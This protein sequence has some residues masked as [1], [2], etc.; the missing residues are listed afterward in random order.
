MGHY[1]THLYGDCNKTLQGSLLNNQDSIWKVRSFFFFVAQA[2][3]QLFQGVRGVFLDSL[4]HQPSNQAFHS[5]F[6]LTNRTN[7]F[8]KDVNHPSNQPF[9]LTFNRPSTLKFQPTFTP[10]S[11]K[12]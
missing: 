2:L 10:P 11:S 5:I 6:K 1:T 12:N 4:I 3:S 9:H 7:H 8:T